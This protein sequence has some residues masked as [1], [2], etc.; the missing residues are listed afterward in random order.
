MQNRSNHVENYDFTN[1]FIKPVEPFR[2]KRYPVPHT[3]V[4][5]GKALTDQ[6]IKEGT[7]YELKDHLPLHLR[8]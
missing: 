1:S 3:L 8:N 2:I 5:I 6:L 7:I 4:P